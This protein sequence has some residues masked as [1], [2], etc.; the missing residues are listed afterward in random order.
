MEFTVLGDGPR[1]A[2]DGFVVDGRGVFSQDVADEGGSRRV[3]FSSPACCA[4]EGDVRARRRR[5]GS[6]RRAQSDRAESHVLVSRKGDLR[7]TFERPRCRRPR[8]GGGLAARAH[9]S[10]MRTPLSEGA[11][12]PRVSDARAP[13]ASRLTRHGPAADAGP[14]H[15]RLPRAPRAPVQHPSPRA[16]RARA[17]E[18]TG[19]TARRGRGRRASAV[20]RLEPPG[21][22]QLI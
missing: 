18:K 10:P 16:V 13:V 20:D 11:R 8:R 15:R 5:R 12:E 9:L 21:A 1:V 7:G 22:A 19:F 4:R 6:G 14:E 17:R 2:R 3:R